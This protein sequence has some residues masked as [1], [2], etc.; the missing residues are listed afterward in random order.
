LRIKGTTLRRYHNELLGCGMIKVKA[1][2][3]NVGYQYEVISYEEYKALHQRI[4]GMLD[5]IINR[6]QAGEPHVSHVKN[7][8]PKKK[9]AS[10]L[11]SVS[12]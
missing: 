10:K 6:L 9:S 1:G 2:K 7:G 5:E 12:R 3:K 8:S 4:D 11:S